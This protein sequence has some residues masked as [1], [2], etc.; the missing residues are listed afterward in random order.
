MTLSRLLDTT[1]LST[2]VAVTKAIGLKLTVEAAQWCKLRRHRAR[3]RAGPFQS[4]RKAPPMLWH[5][6]FRKPRLWAPRIL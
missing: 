2:L 6:T 1:R 3:E 5:S 4:C